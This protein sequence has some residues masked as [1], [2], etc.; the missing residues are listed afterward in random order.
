MIAASSRAM[1]RRLQHQS[2]RFYS[3]LDLARPPI[4]AGGSIGRD[5]DLRVDRRSQ[6]DCLPLL[7]RPPASNTAPSRAQN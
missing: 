3:S 4:L 1:V 6:F 2:R 5:F 7:A